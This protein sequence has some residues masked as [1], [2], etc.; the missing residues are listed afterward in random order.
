MVAEFRRRRDYLVPALNA[1][2]GITLRRAGG[3][4][5]RVPERLGAPGSRRRARRAAARRGRAS[6]CSPG[7]AFGD[8]RDRPSPDLVRLLA[9]ATSSG[10]SSGSRRSSHA[11]TSR[12]PTTRRATARYCRTQ[13][14]RSR[15]RAFPRRPV[16]RRRSELDRG[17]ARAVPDRPRGGHE[18]ALR[19]PA[20]ARELGHVSADRRARRAVRGRRSRSCARRS[21]AGG[22]TFG[23]AGRCIPTEVARRDPASSC[24][25]GRAAC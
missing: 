21:P 3:R 17:G 9:R 10:P 25:K 8:P 5:L 16:R 1:I 22:S 18:R 19:D 7:S 12:S 11:L 15:R 2:P 6:R 13:V 14:P 20:R 23:G 4:V 24:S